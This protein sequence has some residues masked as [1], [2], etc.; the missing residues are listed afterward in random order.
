MTEVAAPAHGRRRR[1]AKLLA[2]LGVAG[3]GLIAANAGNDAGGILAYASAG[4]QFAYRTLFVLVLVTV[5]LVVVQEMCSRLGAYTGQG[6]GSLIREQFPVRASFGALA[7]LLIANA[8]LTVSEF[9]GIGAAMELLGV[10][11]YV[12]IPLALVGLWSLTVFGSYSR[13]ERAAMALSLTFLAYPV[14]AILAHP[15]SRIVA[16]DL[17]TPQFIHSVPFLVLTVALIGT[18]ITPYMQFY[19]ASAVVDKGI[20][21]DKYPAERVDTVNGAILSDIVSMFIVI[22]TAAAIGGSGPLKSARQAAEALVPAVG[23]AAPVLFGIGLLGA[24]LLAAAVVP[25]SSSYA[26]AESVGAPRSVSDSVRRA[27]LFFG[28][29]TLQL[30][31]GAAAAL[32]PGNLVELVVNMQ[33][34]NGVITPVLLAFVLILANRRGVL[35]N[36]ANGR[37]FRIVATVC[38]VTV[39]VLALTVVVLHV[40]GAA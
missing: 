39:G 31:V 17:L 35:G 27:P 12:A 5:A 33:V 2:L 8:G 16:K 37:F 6:L 38:V 11:R 34:L 18:T 13:G 29:F 28:L 40:L 20:G 21:P 25:L 7:L 15:D 14:A 3:P 32:A 1:R 30:V 9:A 36:A 23:S 24:S 10:S 19:V 26:I 4:A 22:A